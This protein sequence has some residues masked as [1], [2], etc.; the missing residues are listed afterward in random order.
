MG[1]LWKPALALFAAMAMIVVGRT[2]RPADF[3]E[4]D[5]SGQTA[6]STPRPPVVPKRTVFIGDSFTAGVGGDGTRWSS[7][8]AHENGWDEVNL[9]NGGTGY[10]SFLSGPAARYACGANLC[11][12]YLRAAEDVADRR[13]ERIFV[14]GGRNDRKFPLQRVD[15][16]S[17][18][19]FTKLRKENPQAKVY[20]ISPF[21]S[22]T[23]YPT[24]LAQEAA[25]IERN[26]KATGCTYLQV[27]SPLTG[28]SDLIIDD[29]VHPSAKGYEILAAAVQTQYKRVS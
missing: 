18:A 21:W 10:V 20:V 22:A 9:A 2:E 14:A 1:R 24:W 11:P 7:L 27:G 6:I 19:L 15:A 23:E 3:R 16:A 26:A 4:M 28:R 29:Q 17:K 8:F 25:A 13:P 5:T 12:D